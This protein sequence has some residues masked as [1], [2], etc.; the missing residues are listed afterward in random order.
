MS[1]KIFWFI[2]ILAICIIGIIVL[3]DVQKEETAG[4]IDYEGQPFIGEETAPVEIVEFG[5]YK[6]PHC[7]EFNDSIFPMIDEQLVETG[8]AKF[9]FMNYSFISADST[10]SAQFAETVFQELGNEKFWD[11][12]H[13]LFEKQTTESGE[14]N[15]FT[16]EFLEEVLTEV[17]SPEETEKVMLAYNKGKG[18]AALKKDL[19]IANNLGI[20]STPV[21]YINGKQFDG[22]SMDDLFTMVEEAVASG[23]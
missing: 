18:E 8:K 10:T 16:D 17:A 22:K 4:N 9:Y 3:K 11:F 5:D 2:G 23:K 1:K 13:L 15:T 21:I 6:C 12:H 7:K 14:L 20:S 19:G